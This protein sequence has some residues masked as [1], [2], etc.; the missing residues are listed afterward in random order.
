MIKKF[1]IALISNNKINNNHYKQ[2]VNSLAWT[3]KI[4]DIEGIASDKVNLIIDAGIIIMN[5][6]N[7]HFIRNNYPEHVMKFVRHNIH[8]YINIMDM[9]LFV[10]DELIEILTWDIE[11]KLKIDLLKFTDDPISIIGK[12]YPVA[13][14]LHILKHNRCATDIK[15][16]YQYYNTQ[17]TEIKE[18][19]YPLALEAISIILANEYP[20]CDE[21]YATLIKDASIDLLPR[22]ELFVNRLKQ[23]DKQ[24]ALVELGNIGI[25]E[26]QTIFEENRRPRFTINEINTVILDAFEE[27]NWI[28]G[29]EEDEKRQ[30]YYKLKKWS[31]RSKNDDIALL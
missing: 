16:L 5:D 11:D 23:Y 14:K 15:W 31:N 1:A 12:D 22:V 3:Y 24:N 28:A 4:F 27:Q 29:Y 7:L 10:F 6:T 20:L 25:T 30:G 2:I 17:P 9:S 8:E 26:F 19:I 18:Y 13:V 21:L